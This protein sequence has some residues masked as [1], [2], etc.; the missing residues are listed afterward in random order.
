VA[1]KQ[2][3]PQDLIDEL[4]GSAHGNLGRVKEILAEHPELVDASARWGETPVQAAAQMGDVEIAEY[5]LNQ[6]APL[7]ICTAAML[8]LADTMKI[9]LGGEP[10][11]IF[12]KGA[13]GLPLLYFTVPH[14]RTRIAELLVKYGARVNDVEGINTPLHAAALFNQPE[15]ATWLLSHGARLNVKDSNGKTPLEIATEKG[16]QE[17]IDVL[18]GKGQ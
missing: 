9:L 7:D 8:G 10:G 5:L 17:V 16:N 6:G 2:A 15:M 4:V 18:S 14:S 3:V 1:E 12:T 13:H 11:L